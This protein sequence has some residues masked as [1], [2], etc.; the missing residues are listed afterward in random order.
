M[1]VTATPSFSIR[2]EQAEEFKTMLPGR[3]PRLSQMPVS[4]RLLMGGQ[5]L[6][7]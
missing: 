5:H 7:L 3:R 4:W 2:P 1:A 6:Y